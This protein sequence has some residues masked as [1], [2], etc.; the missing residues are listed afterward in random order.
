MSPVDQLFW[1][2]TI[3]QILFYFLW[4]IFRDIPKQI[5]TDGGNLKL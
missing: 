4:A 3:S 5:N 2:I 1:V